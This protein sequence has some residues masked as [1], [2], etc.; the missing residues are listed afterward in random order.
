MVECV[1]VAAA[2]F[3]ACFYGVVLNIMKR[4]YCVPF[5]MIYI[6]SSLTTAAR[7]RAHMEH[8]VIFADACIRRHT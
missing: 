4:F 1:R 5:E 7:C 8:T 3:D 6:T 2:E